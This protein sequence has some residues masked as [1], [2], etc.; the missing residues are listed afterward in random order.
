MT[1][2][3]IAEKPSLAQA[4][5]IQLPG[6]FKRHGTFIQVGNDYVTWCVGHLF[7]QCEPED[8]DAKYKQW[9]AD[10]LPIVPDSWKLK[11]RS[12]M[13][14]QFKAI[15]ELVKKSDVIV[16]AGDPDEEG[17]LLVDEVLSFIKTY[18]PV[19]RV[20][21]ND[22]NE[23]KVKQ[24]LAN[25]H[26]NTEPQFR[27]WYAWA[28]ARSRFDWLFGLNL[29][30]AYTVAAKRAGHNGVV[31]VGR[32]QTPTLALVVQRD[33]LIENFKPVPFYVVEA[34]LDHSKGTFIAKWVPTAEQQ[35]LDDS[36]RLIEEPIAR[37]ICAKVNG[38]QANIT[39]YE[40]TPK[41]ENA[42]LLFSLST[43]VK[44]ANSKYGYGAQEVL[45]I[46]QSLYEVHKLTTYPR[47][48]CEYLNN[49]A[50]GE[51]RQILAAV[52]LNRPDLAILVNKT[53]L[54]RK[55]AAFNDNKVTAH[56]AIIP[57]VRQ[58][59]I[60]SLS[61]KERNIYDLIVR[62][63]LAQFFAPYEFLKTTI[64]VV[65]EDERFIATGRTPLSLGWHEIYKPIIEENSTEEENAAQTF[66]A[67]TQGDKAIC[68]ECAILSRKTTPPSRFTEGS[69]VEAMQDIH[70]Y[71]TNPEAK[72]RLKEGEGIGTSATRSAIIETLKTRKFIKPERAGSKK[73]ISTPA[74]RALIASVSVTAKDPAFTAVCEQALNAIAAGKLDLDEFLKRNV[75]LVQNLVK[76]VEKIKLN[77]PASTQSET[78][79]SNQ[80]NGKKRKF[81]GKSWKPLAARA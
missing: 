49:V 38:K 67:V 76:E 56:H 3:F 53:D 9:R 70:K 1:R 12:G 54:K 42:P 75:L 11:L 21:I 43:L 18:K 40:R 33:L 7:E 20:L 35:G 27:G 2:V 47:S 17:Q 10:T 60:T 39:K 41:Q 71:V 5:A 14:K 44:T 37:M 72:K 23:S 15:E 29:T 59:N 26:D 6:K 66:P 8:Y 77:F 30:R 57:T 46:C 48:D 24:A 52:V 22:Y 61:E 25:L 62:S 79:H 78:K 63:Y 32:V 31:S 73:I 65:I 74:G 81:F 55:S 50:H 69:L 45:D 34:K 4:I 28:L 16:N 51:A 19:K 58:A 36:K 13:Q 80:K 68:S 64:E